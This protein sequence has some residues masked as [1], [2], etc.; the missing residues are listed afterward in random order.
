MTDEKTNRIDFDAFCEVLM[1]LGAL[2]SP[3]E[4]QGLF[5]G[6]LCGG[7]KLEE[8]QWQKAAWDLLDL[9]MQPN[10]EVVDFTNQLFISTKEQLKTGDYDLE[11]FLPDDDTTDLDQRTDALAQWCNGFLMGFGSAGIDPNTEFSEDNAQALRD[12]AAI[13]QAEYVDDMDIEEQ[14]SDFTELV[15]YVRVVALNFYEDL[16]RSAE[17]ADTLH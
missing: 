9:A 1:P 15:E 12:L 10:A 8:A 17:Q 6:K 11:I 4:L 3:S 2:H 14:E 7:A 16:V 13:V 5:C